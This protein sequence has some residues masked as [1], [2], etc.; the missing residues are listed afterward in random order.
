MQLFA[1]RMTTPKPTRIGLIAGWGRYPLIVA[2]ELRSAGYEVVTCA[3]RGHADPRLES[4]CHQVRWFGMGQMGAQVRFLRR[5]GVD[6]ATLAGKIFKT[7]LLRRFH[8]LRHLPDMTTL[9][10]F[11]PVFVTRKKDR[12]DDTLLT[13]VTELFQ[14]NGVELVPATEFAPELLIPPGSLTRLQPNR[15]QIQDI[16]FAWQMAKEMG[17]LDIG[18]SVAV[19]SMAVLAVE[20]VEGTDECIRRAG[21]LCR[22]GGFTVVKVAKPQQDMRF[23]VPTIGVG[24]IQTMKD[25]G[26]SVLAI[27]ANRTIVLDRD[28]LVRMAN[29]HGI[30]IIAIEK[31]ALEQLRRVA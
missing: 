16:A 28:E 18:Q 21:Q 26:A 17:R 4:V 14:A 22:G 27:E 23:D 31:D 7:L 12:R 1:S 20:A 24:T 5:N 19:K 2:T 30:A 13:L 9:R 8:F 25:A 11:Y 6:V 3:I 15:H 10:H 29:R